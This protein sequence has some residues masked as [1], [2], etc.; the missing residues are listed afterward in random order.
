MPLFRKKPVEIEARHFS[1]NNEADNKVMND[2]VLWINQGRLEGD[3]HAWH[4]GTD[5]FI[6]TLE[7][8]MRAECFDWIIKGT[9][10]E[11]YPCKPEPFTD[12]FEPAKEP[13]GPDEA[14]E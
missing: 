8:V 4:N 10:G 1:T 2:L 5:I 6:Q 7:G 13:D 3:T 11:F 12:T 14:W 9:R